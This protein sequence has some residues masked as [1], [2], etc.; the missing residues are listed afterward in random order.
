[1]PLDDFTLARLKRQQREA[2]QKAQAQSQ[3]QVKE[4]EQQVQE[5]K[6]ADTKEKV[7]AA[8]ESSRE[9]DLESKVIE[10]PTSEKKVLKQVDEEPKT[11]TDLDIEVTP[12]GG[13]TVSASVVPVVEKKVVEPPTRKVEEAPKPSKKPKRANGAQGAH[14]RNVPH[15]VVTA[16]RAE[17]PSASNNVDAVA[18]FVASRTG[19]YDDLTDEQCRL[20]KQSNREDP[21]VS[22]N[23]KLQA[24]EEMLAK[25]KEVNDELQLAVTYMLFDRL[26]WRRQNPKGP[27]SVDFVEPGVT[28]LAQRLHQQT[29]QVVDIERRRRGRPF[30]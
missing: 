13:T 8:L 24:M 20:A 4:Q 27:E 17:F 22:V 1:M 18:A 11:D 28:Q 29:K 9:K 6:V 21:L 14:L 2:E 10:E 26:G 3:V 5:K 7:D 23:K 25:Q 16:A 15:S 30:R 19:I 12:G